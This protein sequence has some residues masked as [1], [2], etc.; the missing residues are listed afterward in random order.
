MMAGDQSPPHEAKE[1]PAGGEPTDEEEWLDKI[2]ELYYDA[3]GE[4]EFG[5]YGKL[6]RKAKTLPGAEPSAVKPFL[7]QQ[8]AYMLHRPVRK[9]F[10]RI[11]YTVSNLLDDW[12]AEIVDVQ[13][14]AKHNDNHR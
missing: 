13:S 10:P 11:P 3:S 6:L 12:E 9:R 7:E 5:T 8:D 14:L 1:K 2:M 4:T